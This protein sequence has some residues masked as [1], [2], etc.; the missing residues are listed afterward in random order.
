[1]SD[2]RVASRYAKSLIELAEEKGVLEEVQADMQLLKSVISNNRDFELLLLN[3]VVK[4]DKKLNVLTQVFTGKVQPMTLLFFKIVAQKSR[5]SVLLYIAKEFE[6]QYNELKGI[7][8]VKITS[9]TPLLLSDREVLISKLAAET[10]KTIQLE[11]TVDPTLIGGFVLRV[12][13]KQID[14]TVKNKLRRLKNNFKENPYIN[15]L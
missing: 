1:M 6:K 11:E 2:I 5:E 7:Q 14:S 13:D 12:G 15:K 10:G 9:A 4:S 8:V 3:P